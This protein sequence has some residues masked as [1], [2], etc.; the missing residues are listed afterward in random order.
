[1]SRHLRER[2]FILLTLSMLL[3]TG[4]GLTGRAIAGITTQEAKTLD[5]NQEPVLIRSS[6]IVPLIGA[7][8]NHLF[9]YTYTGTSWGQQIPAQV[10]EVAG[11]GAYLAAGD[12]NFNGN[13][14]IVFMTGDLGARAPLTADLAASLPISSTWCELEVSDPLAPSKKGWAYLVRSNQLNPEFAADYADYAAPRI[15]TGRYQV[16]LATTG[17][18]GL[19]YLALNQSGADILDRTKLRATLSLGGNLVITEDDLG[20]SPIQLIRDGPVRVILRR[21]VTST[22]LSN[23]ARLDTTYLGYDSLLQIRSGVSFDLAN[24]VTLVSVRTSTDFSSSIANNATFYNANTPAGGVTVDGIPDAGVDN[25]LSRWSQISHSTGRLIQVTDPA[26]AGG[27]PNTYYR[28]NSSPE[29]AQDTGSPGSYGES[30]FLI[31][32]NVNSSFTTLSSLFVTPA[33][34]GKVGDAY[35]LYSS[36]PLNILVRCQGFNYNF[37]P[38]IF[39]S[40]Q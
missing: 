22:F 27:V 33:G 34:P 37:L 8:V 1:M 11:N 14:E 5:R 18:P 19:D 25:G 32:G 26:P 31:T 12:G 39:K 15:T 9:V 21:A 36:N 10:D 16:G 28:D 38:L 23:Q 2:L 40:S 30:G 20:V 24:G 3:T 7:P 13:D 17:H 6:Q 4:I 29:S 35:D